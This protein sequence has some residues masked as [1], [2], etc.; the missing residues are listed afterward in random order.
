LIVSGFEEIT[1]DEIEI[2]E[3]H[4]EEVGGANIIMGVGEDESLGDAIA[5]TVIA[6]GSTEQQNE[7]SNTEGTRIIHTPGRK[8]N[9]LLKFR[10]DER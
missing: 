3:Q 8:I 10:R 1:I 5:V 7:I 4:P 9:A 2:N 6:T